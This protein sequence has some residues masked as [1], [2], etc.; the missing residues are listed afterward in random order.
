MSQ[1]VDRKHLPQFSSNLGRL[2]WTKAWV[3]QD[4][5]LLCSGCERYDC[6]GSFP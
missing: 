4:S 5:L 2:S 3:L 6:Q 1:G